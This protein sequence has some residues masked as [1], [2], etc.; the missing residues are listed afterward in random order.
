MLHGVVDGRRRGR[1]GAEVLLRWRH[2]VVRVGHDRWLTRIVPGV[3]VG[4]LSRAWPARE[5]VPRGRVILDGH[6]DEI[7]VLTGRYRSDAECL[8]A[9]GGRGWGVVTCGRRRLTVGVVAAVLERVGEV[10]VVLR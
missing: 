5:R 2:H 1:W 6:G 9:D 10:N 8:G 4:G 3:V 7:A